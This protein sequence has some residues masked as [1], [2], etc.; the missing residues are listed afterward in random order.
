MH[1]IIE[2]PLT[3]TRFRGASGPERRRLPLLVCLVAIFLGCDRQKQTAATSPSTQPTPAREV[4]IAAAADLKFALDEL[5]A[6]FRAKH[7]GVAVT[8]TYGSS[9]NFFAQLSNEAPFDLFLSADFYYPQ[10]LL[11][12][13]KGAPGTLFR[14]AVGRIVAWVPTDSKLDVEKRGLAAL[15][16][17][18]VR[19]IAIANPQHAPYGRAAEA[20]LRAAGVYDKVKGRLVLGENVAQAAQFVQSGAADAGVVALSLAL[21]PAMRDKGRYWEVPLDVYPRIEQGGVVL[22][23]AKDSEAANDFRLFMTSDEGKAVLKT[24]G[25]APAGIAAAP[26]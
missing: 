3:R 6:A 25:F 16:D 11:E 12:Q 21:S 8:P 18:S 17:D 20:A 22:K 19:K 4:R 26:G 7:P 14:Y 15:A 2:C 9:G 23:W 1:P 24:Y 5:S 10:R 13:G